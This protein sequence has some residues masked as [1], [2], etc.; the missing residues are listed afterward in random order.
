MVVIVP[1]GSSGLLNREW[2]RGV[3]EITTL[4]HTSANVTFN[5]RI[6]G[7]RELLEQGWNTSLILGPPREDPTLEA[8]SKHVRQIGYTTLLSIVLI[9]PV[10]V[11]AW[12]P[13]PEARIVYD[14]VSLALAAII[15]SVIAG[16]FC[17]KVLKS[18]I[19][20]KVIE[21][22]LLIVL[23]TAAAFVFV[24]SFGYIVAGKPLSTGDF[25]ETNTLLVILIMVGRYVAALV[26]QKAIESISLR[27]I[28]T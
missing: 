26:R 15:Q 12:A 10:L 23:R 28:Q 13:L 6:T 22:D 14:S 16:P 27:S 4:D 19:F 1:S 9:V 8:G 3:T 18:L 25:F 21:M 11:L 5:A 7:A 24:V 20:S 2:P 17:P